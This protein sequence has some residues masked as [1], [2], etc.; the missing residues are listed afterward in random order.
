MAQRFFKDETHDHSGQRTEHE[1]YEEMA[2]RDDLGL[3]AA[4]ERSHEQIEP[5]SSEIDEQ[6]CG[7]A[8]MEHHEKRQE[9]R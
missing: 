5:F 8:E 3:T 4:A 7:G 2:L 9:T 1:E 6:C